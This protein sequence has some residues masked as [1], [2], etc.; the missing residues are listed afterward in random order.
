[1]KTEL[2]F[3]KTEKLLTFL[4]VSKGRIQRLESLEK[5]LADNILCL[6]NSLNDL[7]RIPGLTA[8]YGLVGE[9]ARSGDYDYA[10]LMTEYEDQVDKITRQMIQKYRRLVSIRYRLHNLREQIAPLEAALRRATAEEQLILEQKF[11]FRNSNYHIADLLH[12]SEKRVRY[13][14]EKIIYQ[15]ADNLGNIRDKKEQSGLIGDRA[16]AL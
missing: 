16:V 5:L 8:K 10:I 2:W 13:I 9:A 14:Y 6:E 15:I 11:F 7:K 1:M 3:G 12:C 4:W